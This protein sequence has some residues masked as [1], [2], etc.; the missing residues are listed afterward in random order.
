MQQKMKAMIQRVQPEIVALEGMTAAGMRIVIAEM[1]AQTVAVLVMVTQME[2]VI[3]NLTEYFIMKI[4]VL[5]IVLIAFSPYANSDSTEKQV[6]IEN[7]QEELPILFC[8]SGDA[9]FRVCTNVTEESCLVITS[10]LTKHCLEKFEELFLDNIPET[11]EYEYGQYIG[12]CVS[13]LIHKEVGS[14]GKLACLDESNWDDSGKLK[15]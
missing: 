1:V 8:E 4:R 13:R 3:F 14:T 5:F 12:F 7:M 10:D 11:S 9:L 15:K 2:M 6:W